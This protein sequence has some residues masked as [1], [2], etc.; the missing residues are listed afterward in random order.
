MR[1]TGPGS[2]GSNAREEVRA[3]TREKNRVLGREGGKGGG[4]R[5]EIGVVDK[6]GE[7]RGERK[8]GVVVREGEEGTG[9][10]EAGMVNR[11]RG[12]RT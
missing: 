5:A 4:G 3:E 11:G 10:G 2:I 9:G 1:H 12:G 8:R 6:E 7:R